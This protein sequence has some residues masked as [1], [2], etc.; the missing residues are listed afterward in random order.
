MKVWIET[1]DSDPLTLGGKGLFC[2]KLAKELRR[3][4]VDVT[5]MIEPVDISL[6]IVRIKHRDAKVKVLRLD[7]VWHDTGKDYRK[8]N[9]SIAEAIKEADGVIYQSQFGKRMADIFVQRPIQ[10]YTIIFNGADPAQYEGLPDLFPDRKVCIAFSRWR[11]HKRLVDIVESWKLAAAKL[12]PEVLL[13]IAGD[14]SHSGVVQHRL[15]HPQIKYVGKLDQEM[16]SNVL[17]HAWASIHLCWFDACPNSVVE[18]GVAGVP[19]ICN[20]VGGTPEIVALT[21]GFALP[22]DSDYDYTAVDLY[23]P[24]SIDRG[25]VGAALV[26]CFNEPPAVDRTA[27]SIWKAATSYLEFF[28]ELL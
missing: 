2:Y 10:P 21:G 22:I 25:L 27:L 19:V 9:L 23:H 11:P 6:N 12:P 26:K 24:P 5:S 1:A 17:A 8:K 15:K 28:N 13:V 7:G 18:A 14:L 16:L 20:N 4:G 3:I